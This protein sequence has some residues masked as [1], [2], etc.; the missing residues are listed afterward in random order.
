MLNNL[1]RGNAGGKM[2]KNNKIRVLIC[3]LM[4]LGTIGMG[5]VARAATQYPPEGGQWN[6]GVGV[7]GSYSDYL[8]SQV[9][10]GSTVKDGQKKYSASAPA[11][12]WSQALAR[13]VYSGCQFYYNI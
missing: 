5:N 7:L 8:N 6:Y 13:G 2:L 10:H 9:T 4:L 12:S 1:K 11:G 3:S